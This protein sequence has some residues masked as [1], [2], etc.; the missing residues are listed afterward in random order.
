MTQGSHGSLRTI[1]IDDGYFPPSFKEGR[2]A[3][4]MVGVLC[5]NVHPIDLGIKVVKVDGLDATSKAISVVKELSKNWGKIEAIFLDGV[6]FAGFNIINP[7]LMHDV[8]GYPVIT[9][10]KHQL[11]LQ[12]IKV[13]LMNNFSDWRKRYSVIESVYEN[14]KEVRT[15]WRKLRISSYGL[16][17]YVIA[18]IIT[19][20]Q[21]TSPLPEPLRL[22]DLIASGLTKESGVLELLNEGRPG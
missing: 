22:A 16:D 7:S 4:L 15:G 8:L 3:T 21:L 19:D 14:S 13:A 12:K 5:K 17:L 1:G 6:T 11:N 10:F 2:L 9:I 20:L 18:E